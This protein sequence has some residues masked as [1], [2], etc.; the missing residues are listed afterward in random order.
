MSSIKR[1]SARIRK[2]IAK[3]VQAERS[4]AA[5]IS[6]NDQKA[7]KSSE[8]VDIINMIKEFIRLFNRIHEADVQLLNASQMYKKIRI[9]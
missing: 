8:I 6:Q 1:E 4:L 9:K 2:H 5:L 7:V 3:A